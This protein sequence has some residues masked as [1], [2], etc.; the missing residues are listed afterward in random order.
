MYISVSLYIVFF[1]VLGLRRRMRSLT[2]RVTPPALRQQLGR[3][4]V[5]PAV[6]FRVENFYFIAIDLIVGVERTESICSAPKHKHL[7]ADNSGRMKISPSSWS[8]LQRQTQ[9]RYTLN[10]ILYKITMFK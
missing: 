9:I 7:A 5:E 1:N 4:R 10:I 6:G 3:R 8:T 2:G